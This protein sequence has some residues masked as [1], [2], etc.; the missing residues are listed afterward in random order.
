MKFF[1]GLQSLFCAFFQRSHVE[2]DMNEELSAHIQ[3]RAHDLECSGLPR[4]EAQRRARIEF[5]GQERFKEEIRE[6]LGTCFF[7]TLWQDLRFGIRTLRK[8]PGFTTVAILTLALG[9]G[10]NTA[11]FSVIQGVLLTPPPFAQPSRLFFVFQYNFTQKH[12]VALSYPD[13]LDWQRNARSFQQMA[14]ITSRSF[15]LTSP[16]TPEH[17]DGD[18]VSAGFF[19]TLGVKLALGRDFAPQE[20][21]HGG[22]PAAIIGDRVWKNRFGASTDVL[23]KTVTLDGVDYTI[24]GVLPPEFHSLLRAS[25][26]DVYTPIAQGNPVVMNDRTIHSCLTVA[27]LKPEA[28]LAQAETE[29]SAVQENLDQLY[30][31]LDRGL[32]AEI[33]PLNKIFI[34]DVRETLLLLFGA[35]G[36]VLLI[37]CANVANLLLARSAGRSREFAIRSA[38]GASRARLDR[39][40]VTE[41]VL[42]SL[43]GGILGLA[44]TRGALSAVLATLPDALPRSENIRVNVTVLLFAFAVSVAVGI[45]FGLAPALKSSRLDLQAKLREGGR[46]ST[47]AHHRAQSTLVI[48]QTALTLILLA[49]AGLLFRTIRHLAE[50]DPGFNA[51]QVLTFNVGVSPSL[52]KTPEDTRIAYRQL[53]ERIRQIPGVQAADLTALLP[54][55][56]QDNSGPFWV[57]TQ[58]P[59]SLA[60]APRVLFYWTGPQ[61]LQTMQIPLL[62][63]RFLNEN[64]TLNSDRVVVIDS[65]LA[66]SYFQDRDPI[67]QTIMIPHWGLARIIGVAGHVKHWELGDSLHYSQN[68]LYASLYQLSNEFVPAFFPYVTVALR[69]PLDTASILP[70]IKTA[71]GS[72]GSEQPVY[73]VQTMRSLV[74]ESMTSQRFPMMLLGA[75]A[76]LA[77]L[78]ASVGIYGVISYSVAQRTQEIGIRMALGAEKP[79]VL[80]M[81]IGQGLRMSLTGVS[82]GTVA[83]LILA[84]LVSSFSHLLYGVGPSDPQTFFIISFVLTSVAVFASYL[85]ARRAMRTD[86]VVA[87]RYE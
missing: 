30:P 9:I 70:E 18:E 25:D 42:L 4:A 71:V 15:D 73:N 77:L 61:Y 58:A 54:L 33:Q 57:G 68:Q 17:L 85:P 36:V 63:G 64:D 53:V 76:A 7:D 32:G 79:E 20:D 39:Q 13:F 16:G 35:V 66:H 72:N 51:Q 5:G 14:A 78:L 12:I 8:S 50:V 43:A 1:A 38:L 69:T 3:N 84:R 87:L 23:G 41:S 52:R 2:A 75:F 26:V 28:T 45:L 29:M 48:V 65:V 59:A 46:G 62:R 49:G 44:L 47:N 6:A 74:S 19:N 10:A 60:E 67:G 27:R 22:A 80:R 11:I 37:A 56:N 34:G 81:V 86:P 83:A 21:R 82:I 31:A 55:T 40:L 24:V